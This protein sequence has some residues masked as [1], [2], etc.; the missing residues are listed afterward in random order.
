M[1]IIKKGVIFILTV[2][3]C[4]FIFWGCGQEGVDT[5]SPES[6][7]KSLIRSYQ[8]QDIQAV[9]E[10]YGIDTDED[11]Q[12]DIQKEM[13]YNLRL[14]KAY[15]AESIDFEKSDCLG[16]SGDSQLIYVRYN[17]ET[18]DGDKKYPALSFYFV[19]KKDKTYCVVPAKGVT[20]EMSKYSRSAY[21]K[22]M[23]TS[24]YKNYEKDL[25][26]FKKNYP[27][28][29]EELDKRFSQQANDT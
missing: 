10:C 21:E 20:E 15:Q 16:K 26:E 28:Y 3:I 14:F 5:K 29:K 17:F 18:E 8:E 23:G 11:A 1:S 4:M 13:D 25:E 7:V 24:T 22:F 9:K 27:S 19:N 12:E 2:S 6:V